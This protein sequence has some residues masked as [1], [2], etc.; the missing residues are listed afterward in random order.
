MS[1]LLIQ[2]FCYH[3]HYELKIFKNYRLEQFKGATISI[4]FRNR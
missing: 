2:Y 1:V 3:F 4:Q